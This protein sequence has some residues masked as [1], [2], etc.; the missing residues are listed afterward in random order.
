MADISNALQEVSV[1]SEL[2]TEVIFENVAG[3]RRRHW[4]KG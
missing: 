1:H 3:L 2:T 4:F